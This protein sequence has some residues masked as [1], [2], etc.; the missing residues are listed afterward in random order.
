MN[1]PYYTYPDAVEAHSVEPPLRIR[2]AACKGSE[3]LSFSPEGERGDLRNGRDEQARVICR[4]CPGIRERL[5]AFFV[6]PYGFVGSQCQ[7][8]RRKVQARKPKYK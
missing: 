1:N 7:R 6:E 5:A 8:A 2:D 3:E 4:C